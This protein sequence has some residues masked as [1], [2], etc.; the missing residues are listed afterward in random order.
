MTKMTWYKLIESEPRDG[1]LNM[2]VDQFLLD[3]VDAGKITSP[4][5]RI[6]S[7][8]RPT[9]SLGYHQKWQSNVNLEALQRHDAALVRRWTGGR[10]VL[11][12]REITYSVV[13]PAIPPFGSRVTHNYLLIGK[14]LKRFTDLGRVSGQLALESTEM[15]N[16]GMRNAP[17]FASLSSS[18]IENSG[19]KMIGS[20]QKLGK[21]GFLQHGSIPL[22]HRADI[23]EEI[24]GTSLDMN[25]FMTSLEEHYRTA[26]LALPDKEALAS[27]LVA[28]FEDEFQVQFLDLR[29]T[30][31]VDETAIAKI[32]ARRF[33]RDSWTFR[34]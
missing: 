10:A 27:K 33:C 2:A 34:K 4:V 32:A 13:S 1:A 16:R 3:L 26:G 20:A 11:H 25:R 14:A 19:R 24:T 15:P 5:L 22:S 12:D 21:A 31:F 29:E 23:L 17:C 9:L 18:E 6:Y 28:A 30:E 8:T 7:W